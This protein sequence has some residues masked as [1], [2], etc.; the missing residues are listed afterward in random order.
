MEDQL[1]PIPNYTKFTGL[2]IS[3]MKEGYLLFSQISV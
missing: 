3:E 1:Y 2:V